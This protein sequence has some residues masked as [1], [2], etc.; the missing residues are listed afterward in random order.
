MCAWWCSGSP[1]LALRYA[2]VRAAS[3][4]VCGRGALAR[5]RIWGTASGSATARPA[6]SGFRC[7]S[8]ARHS[9]AASWVLEEG[10]HNSATRGGRAPARGVGIGIGLG[11]VTGMGIGIGIGITELNYVVLEPVYQIVRQPAWS[12]R[13]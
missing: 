1:T 13:V 5:C 12:L 4:R 10:L 3:I 11:I 6:R 2:A 7:T 8:A 9:R